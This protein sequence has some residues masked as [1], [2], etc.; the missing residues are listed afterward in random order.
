MQIIL[1]WKWD[2]QYDHNGEVAAL[3]SDHYNYIHVDRFHCN[4][5]PAVGDMILHE[6]DPLVC[7]LCWTETSF[8][9]VH[10]R[11]GNARLTIQV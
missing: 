11:Y 6:T 3:N 10:N 8:C 1:C 2:Q 9:S 7:Y 5:G 4:P